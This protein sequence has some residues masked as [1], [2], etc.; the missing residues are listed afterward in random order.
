MCVSVTL[1]ALPP[2]SNIIQVTENGGMGGGWQYFRLLMASPYL[3][4]SD[5]DYK[6]FASSPPA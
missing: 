5:V 1:Y 3:P 6:A 4:N 2:G